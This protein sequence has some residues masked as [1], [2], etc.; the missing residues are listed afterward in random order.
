MSAMALQVRPVRPSVAFVVVGLP[1]PPAEDFFDDV[2]SA[3]AIDFVFV[4]SVLFVRFS[5]FAMQAGWLVRLWP[6]SRF[7]ASRRGLFIRNPD[8]MHFVLH[9][10]H[11]S[12]LSVVTPL[13]VLMPPGGRNEQVG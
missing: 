13:A 7:G 5:P 12:C 2:V 10:F 6:K 11:G 4:L 9:C 8:L 1:P 3:F